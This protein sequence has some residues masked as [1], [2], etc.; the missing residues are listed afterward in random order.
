LRD[1]MRY[2]RVEERIADMMTVKAQEEDRAG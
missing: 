2:L 1:G